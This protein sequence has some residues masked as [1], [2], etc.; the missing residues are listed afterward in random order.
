MANYWIP[1]KQIPEDYKVVSIFPPTENDVFDYNSISILKKLYKG[2]YL[3]NGTVKE[4]DNKVVIED[5]HIL[6]GNE[7]SEQL[8][9]Y[10]SKEYM[11][12]SLKLAQC[13]LQE[14]KE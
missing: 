1:Y 4:I 12:S 8:F 9:S 10:L 7:Y 5:E 3:T 2:G 14:R 13:V 11:D 6:N